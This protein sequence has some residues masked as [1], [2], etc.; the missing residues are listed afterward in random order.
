[1]IKADPLGSGVSKARPATRDDS[2]AI[3]PV[4]DGIRAAA[5]V[6]TPAEFLA[7]ASYFIA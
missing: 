2:T 5:P 4:V 6:A 7:I 3:A 1:L